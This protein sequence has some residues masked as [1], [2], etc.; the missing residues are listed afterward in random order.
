VLLFVAGILLGFPF[1]GRALVA[2]VVYAW[3]RLSPLQPM[4]FQFGVQ[5]NAWHLPFCLAAIDCLSV[6]ND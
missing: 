1:Q 6:R 3:S 5:I 4:N 2:A